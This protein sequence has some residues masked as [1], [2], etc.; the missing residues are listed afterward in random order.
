M[1]V[2]LMGLGKG[3]Q[4]VAEALLASSW[5]Q[6]VAVAS[7]RSHRL[8]R[9]VEKHPDIAAYDDYRSLIVENPLDALFV[10]IPP[11]LRGKYLA[12]AA[13]HRCPVWML[14]PVARQFDEA[15]E[16]VEHFERARC[17][18]AVARSWG[19]EPAI[20][21]EALDLERLGRFFFARGNVMTCVEEDLDWRGDSVRAGGGVLLDRG[22]ELVD[23]VVKVM[24]MPATVYA[25]AKGVSRPGGRFPY[26]TEDTAAVVCQF[27]G[28]AIATISS[29]WTSGPERCDVEF[30]GTGGSIL[31]D[32]QRVVCR[33]R[34]GDRVF[35]DQPRAASPLLASI[36]N[37]LSSLRS[38]PERI[39]S[40]VRDHLPTMA[41]IQAAYL[42]ART[43][44]PESPSKIFEMHDVKEPVPK[45]GP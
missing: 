7:R 43:G 20:Q 42:S 13:E 8:D 33:D 21:P 29:C 9:F 18:V 30:F 10:A 2:G 45:A 19:I 1:K 22:Y 31:I 37:F 12:L 14:T 4:L 6:V 3:G 5:C 26:D 38:N 23:M 28:G 27:A 35:S 36:E 11:F 40:S 44:Q 15:V 32:Q 34:T 17:P 25:L 39:R 24:G 41:V 16:I